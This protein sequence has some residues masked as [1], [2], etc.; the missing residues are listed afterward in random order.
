[1]SKYERDG[2]GNR[3]PCPHCDRDGWL[4]R[5]PEPHREDVEA[6]VDELREAAFVMENNPRCNASDYSE[7]MDRAATA[8]SSRPA[9]PE[10]ERKRCAEI[11][12]DGYQRCA[13]FDGHGGNH[14]LLAPSG[15]PWFDGR[16]E[17][18]ER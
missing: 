14:T 5:A 16:P 18:D 15:A 7:L 1:M 3:I 11:A 4:L 9:E 8:L 6:L 13:D 17:G 2:E 12:P 10:G